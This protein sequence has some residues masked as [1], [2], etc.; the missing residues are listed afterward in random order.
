[1]SEVFA[2]DVEVDEAT[3]AFAPG[4]VVDCAPSDALGVVACPPLVVRKGVTGGGVGVLGVASTL[5]ET[6]VVATFGEL[7]VCPG[8]VVVAELE[9]FLKRAPESVETG[10]DWEVDVSWPSTDDTSMVNLE[11]TSWTAELVTVVAGS[12]GVDGCESTGVSV[13]S[14]PD[15]GELPGVVW[16]PSNT[17]GDLAVDAEDKGELEVAVNKPVFCNPVAC[18]GTFITRSNSL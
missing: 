15:E 7:V 11:V 1:M 17:L 2:G 16:A 14:A 4:S 3:A 9:V 12:P 6:D 10:V 8:R 13:T 18:G 5:V